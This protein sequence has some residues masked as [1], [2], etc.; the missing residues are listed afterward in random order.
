MFTIPS[1]HPHEIVTIIPSL[2]TL[3]SRYAL[4]STSGVY[5]YEGKLFIGERHGIL[6]LRP[7][8][9][10]KSLYLI[11]KEERDIPVSLDVVT[12]T[13]TPCTITLKLTGCIFENVP[14]LH[15][16]V[17]TNQ[18]ITV[19]DLSFY[20]QERL[21]KSM[22]PLPFIHGDLASHAAK[23]HVVNSVS[24]LLT[25]FGRKTGMILNV[26]SISIQ[27]DTGYLMVDNK[28]LTCSEKGDCWEWD[29]ENN[30]LTLDG[31]SSSPIHTNGNLTI[32]LKENSVN[33]INCRE[34]TCVS[35]SGNLHITGGGTLR[36]NT[37]GK[38]HPVYAIQAGSLTIDRCSI[39]T[40]M[41]GRGH[42]IASDFDVI[43]S[44]TQLFASA[45]G[46]NASSIFAVSTVCLSESSLSLKSTGGH[47][48]LCNKLEVGDCGKIRVI[49]SGNKS[50]VSCAFEK[51]PSSVIILA[52]SAPNN[53]SEW[54]HLVCEPLLY[55]TS[56]T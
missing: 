9:R 55:L 30:I 37:E 53:L 19:S 46:D 5:L 14:L 45:S 38:T 10:R 41:A 26:D 40:T 6:Q 28:Y 43:I 27:S 7:F 48:I 31:Y 2:R 17:S 39:S 32:H 15:H 18:N 4:P 11:T 36:L 13:G 44:H 56:K 20:L 49:T 34:E 21:E 24:S 42:V 50:A 51:I 8:G 33:S 22:L 54:P 47:A 35:T 3:R 29:K 25:E 1:Q 52:G 23:E 16:A 12:Q